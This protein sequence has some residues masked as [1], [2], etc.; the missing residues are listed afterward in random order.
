MVGYKLDDEGLGTSLSRRRG[1]ISLGIC[2]AV[3]RVMTVVRVRPKPAG[4][5]YKE[6]AT[7]RGAT[8]EPLNA[9]RGYAQH[10][11]SAVVSLLQ[12]LPGVSLNRLLGCDNP[13]PKAFEQCP[14]TRLHHHL[15]EPVRDLLRYVLGLIPDLGRRSDCTK[16]EPLATGER[17]CESISAFTSLL[18]NGVLH[19]ATREVA[20]A[21]L[22]VLDV[23]LV[24]G[25]E[26][27]DL[28]WK[29]SVFAG[30]CL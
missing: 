21:L 23:F 10:S 25:G 22:E 5:V 18:S 2:E 16:E 1:K 27:V 19:G 17:R 28:V 30:W 3:M 4:T 13:S 29:M 7:V 8:K 14:Q 6:K 15:V 12:F 9:Y 20:D 26:L 24:G 11:P